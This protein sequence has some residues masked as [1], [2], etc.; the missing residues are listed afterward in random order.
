VVVADISQPGNEEDQGQANPDRL[1]IDF[2]VLFAESPEVLL[3][4]R[5]DS[6]RFTMVAATNA[7]LRATH[8]TRDSLGRGL[9]EVF[10]DNPDDPEVTGTS[11][12]RASLE[13]V[14]ATRQPDTMAVQKY[15][16]RGADGRFET[17]YWS[18]KNLPVLSPQGEVE[19]ILHRVED[20]TELVRASE[21]G[22][23]LRGRE[24]EMQRE[25][26]NRS[27]ELAAALRELRATN[28]KLA[29]TD[30]AK[31]T[32][33]SNI[34]HEFRTPLTLILGTLQEEL[35]TNVHNLPPQSRLQI[36]TAHRNCL[37]LLKLVNTLLDF[38]RV[39]AGRMQ[40][41]YQ[42]TDL[43]VL[44]TELT[45]NF[46]SAVER[47][48]LTLT[49]DCAPLPEPIYVDHEMWE[50]IV[51]NLLSNAFKHT[52]KGGIA[53]RLV[54]QDGSVQ[55]CVEDSGIGI[56]PADVPH[57]FDRFHRIQG[58]ASRTHEGSGIGLALVKELVQLH[59][60]LIE[61]QS[62]VGRGT[63]FTVTLQAGTAHLPAD[64]IGRAE[65]SQATGQFA[66]AALQ[67]ALR[68]IPAAPDVLASEH[69]QK[70]SKAP[71]W[72]IPRPVI[73]LADDNADMRA[74]VTR[75]LGPLYDVRAVP[76]GQAALEAALAAPP[77]LVLTDVMMPR[78][79][80]FGLLRALRADRRT[81]SLP[82]ILLSARAGE[83]AAVA[84]LDTGADDYLVK[85][86]SARELLARVRT[87][88]ELGWQ[89]RAWA[90]E[91]ELRVKQRTA[92]L[93]VQ[94]QWLNLLDQMTLAIAGRQDPRSVFQLVIRQVEAQ[95]PADVCWIGL[96]DEETLWEAL[97]AELFYAPDVSAESPRLPPELSELGLRAIVATPLRAEG[98]LLGVLLAGR[99]EPESFS[100]GECEFL[101]QLSERLAITALRGQS[102]ESLQPAYVS[103]A[104]TSS[105]Q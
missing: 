21:L 72:K 99:R 61:V 45:A 104:R 6:P 93:E 71:S 59:A 98:A 4:L 31:T 94:V 79:D 14:L 55:F 65:D 105:R 11:N 85:P 2:Q 88:V 70:A 66:A 37:R 7:R 81:Q 90:D 60:G 22:A 86:F 42:P 75:L 8:T 96:P 74:Y 57:L 17:K 103:L 28:L 40:A 15:D 78:L 89:R 3:V 91:L 30:V 95:L 97:G 92:R 76:D 32:F 26:I 12:L 80:G 20:V 46:T 33:F 53:V 24:H 47:G 84:G 48:G 18:P 1:T 36:Q 5:P 68:W 10:P 39:E 77:D 9:F 38:A 101:R 19:Y 56:A 87:H 16:I 63:R 49:V 54:W 27:N 51:L 23:V 83:D 50:K 64:K 69:A 82:I 41:N 43:A 29:E 73:L 62:E 34:S 67:E 58:A 52:F 25:V 44:T 100:G 102:R 35:S 13:R